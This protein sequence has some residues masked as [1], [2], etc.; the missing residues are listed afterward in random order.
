MGVVGERVE[1]RH[2]GL[3]DREQ[4]IHRRLGGGEGIQDLGDGNVRAGTEVTEDALAFSGTEEGKNLL[5]VLIGSMFGQNTQQ[6]LC[7]G[8]GL[9]IAAPSEKI[10]ASR[11]KLPSLIVTPHGGPSTP[12]CPQENRLVTQEAGDQQEIKYM[13][14]FAKVLQGNIFWLIHVNP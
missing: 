10:P 12:S 11:H 13:L 5:L 14:S 9:D 4:K 6:R 8:V 3:K 2:Q 1:A 7:R